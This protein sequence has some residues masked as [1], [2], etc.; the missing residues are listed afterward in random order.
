MCGQRMPC[1]VLD[2]L[3]C[4]AS[5]GVRRGPTAAARPCTGV[6]PPESNWWPRGMWA[7][8]ERPNG[9]VARKRAR[10]HVGYDTWFNG[11]CFLFFVR[12]WTGDFPSCW[13]AG[14][15]IKM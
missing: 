1:F 10:A 7:A 6:E 14:T 12:R 9:A 4:N 15:E 2:R 3:V 13:M 5:G 8:E 11:A